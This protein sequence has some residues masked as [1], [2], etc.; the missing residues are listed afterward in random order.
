MAMFVVQI[1][2][3]NDAFL[4]RWNDEVARILRYAADRVEYNT[5]GPLL[6]AN[7]NTVGAYGFQAPEGGLP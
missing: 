5:Y 4:P 3:D 6:D 7:G 2:T 1:D